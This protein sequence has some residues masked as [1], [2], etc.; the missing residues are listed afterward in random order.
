MNINENE[1]S[2]TYRSIQLNLLFVLLPKAVSHCQAIHILAVPFAM[3]LCAFNLSFCV[4]LEYA[5]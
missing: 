3:A 2:V 5:V 4:R 1:E